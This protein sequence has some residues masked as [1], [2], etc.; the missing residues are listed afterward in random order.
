MCPSKSLQTP[1]KPPLRTTVSHLDLRGR[2]VVEASSSLRLFPGRLKVICR[3]ITVARQTLQAPW[4][5]LF[6]AP[7]G[8]STHLPRLNL[9]PVPTFPWSALLSVLAHSG[10][11]KWRDSRLNRWCRYHNPYIGSEKLTFCIG[12]EGVCSR[13]D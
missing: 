12:D 3:S 1:S 8:V 13:P 6:L 11:I 2:P 10:I 7:N 5:L 4:F 9:D